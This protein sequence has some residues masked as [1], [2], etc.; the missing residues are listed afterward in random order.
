MTDDDSEAKLW[1][2]GQRLSDAFCMAIE[3]LLTE[4][5]ESGLVP[6]LHV[7]QT[8]TGPRYT[9]TVDGNPWGAVYIEQTPTSL[10]V[11]RSRAAGKA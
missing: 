6:Q 7:Q 9:V 8:D 1:G 11:I 4:A 3:E 5:T 2:L 10:R